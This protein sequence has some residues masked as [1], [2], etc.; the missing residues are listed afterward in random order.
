MPRRNGRN[1]MGFIANRWDRLCPVTC[2]DLEAYISSVPAALQERDCPFCAVVQMYTVV[3]VTSVGYI[4][5][6]AGVTGARVS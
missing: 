5:I 4:C 6:F 3:V 1:I 2:Q